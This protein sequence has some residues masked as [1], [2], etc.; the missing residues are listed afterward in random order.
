MITSP[1]LQEKYRVQRKLAEEAGYDVRKHF[2]LCRKIV[3]ETEA[4]YGLKF[5][6][7]KREGGELGQ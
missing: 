4:E 7:G 1:I 2:E 5:K 3:A 6:Y